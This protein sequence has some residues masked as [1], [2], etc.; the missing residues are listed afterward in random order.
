M[1]SPTL[2]SNQGKA[3]TTLLL[4]VLTKIFLYTMATAMA[5]SLQPHQ[6]LSPW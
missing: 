3:N 1:V 6:C 5:T 2:P 4:M